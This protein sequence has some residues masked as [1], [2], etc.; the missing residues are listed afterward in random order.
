MKKKKKLTADQIADMA[1]HGEDVTS[2][3]SSPTKG[4]IHRTTLDLSQDLMGDI[5][6]IA[7]NLNVSRQAIIKLAMQ[8]YVIK[9]KNAKQLK[10]G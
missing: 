9:W 5:D 6:F 2:Y 3:M 10:L 4:G 7:H 8:D 1:D